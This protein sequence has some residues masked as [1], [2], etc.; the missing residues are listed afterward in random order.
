ML[1]FLFWVAVLYFGLRVIFRII[2]PLLLG[3]YMR[4]RQDDISTPPKNE[5]RIRLEDEDGELIIPGKK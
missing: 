3:R 2:I 5:R 1:K 4:K